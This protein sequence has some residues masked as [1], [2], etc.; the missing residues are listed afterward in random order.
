MEAFHELRVDACVDETA[1]SARGTGQPML[2]V[3][4]VPKNLWKK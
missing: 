3:M 2:S 1:V 4:E